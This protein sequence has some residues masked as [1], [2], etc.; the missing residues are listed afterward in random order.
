MKEKEAQVLSIAL[1]GSSF[2]LHVRHVANLAGSSCSNGSLLLAYT[3]FAN[4]SRWLLLV[5]F[6]SKTVHTTTSRSDFGEREQGQKVTT[7]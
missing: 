4:C 1:A 6:G 7:W 3:R 2:G 5:Y